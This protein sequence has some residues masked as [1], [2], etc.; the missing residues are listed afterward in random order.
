M[1]NGRP[2]ILIAGAGVAGLEALIALREHLGGRAHIELL[3]PAHEFVYRPMAVAEPFGAGAVRRFDLERVAADFGA[4][5]RAD[6]L[7]SVDPARHEVRTDN[8]YEITY[9]RLLVTVGAHGR[10]AVP[11]SLAFRGPEDAPA[12]AELLADA[13]AGTI[14]RIAF[15]APVGAAWVLPL[16]ELALMT[17]AHLARRGAAR[18]ELVVVTPEP[19]PLGAFGHIAGWRIRELLA[20][21][22]IA[23]YGDCAAASVEPD[24][25]LL[26]DGTVVEAD[27]VV[28][29]PRL[30]G[31]WVSGLPHD[32]DGFIPVDPHGAVQGAD[33]V[34]A[35]GDG[36]TFPIKQGGLASQQ[37]DAAAAAIA[38][39]LGAELTAEPFRPVL[40]GLLLDGRTPRYLR[41]EPG[42]PGPERSDVSLGALWWPPAKVAARH[43][44]PYLANPQP[45]LT[46]ETELADREA[47]PE[48]DDDGELALE[49][50]AVADLNLTMADQ[51]AR[52]GEF[53]LALRCLDAV[54]MLEGVLPAGYA[55]KRR[56]WSERVTPRSARR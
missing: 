28:S 13:E 17:C 19:A 36:T 29:I 7:A 35:A 20:E 23:F 21:R 52:L 10:N 47:L 34:Y 8:G 18:V 51:N 22:A 33:D 9:D 49:L 43:L 44:A 4:E 42:A 54:E 27:R 3:D 39:G 40:R 1:K 24:G 55:A 41:G 53:K 37:A 11:G 46:A 32:A 14:E 50:H 2:T 26:S 31:P 56:E 16:Y 5:H 45:H 38:S 48:D 6:R 25:L 12:F 30:T 15:A